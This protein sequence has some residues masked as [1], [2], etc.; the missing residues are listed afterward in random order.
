MRVLAATTCK[1]EDRKT[2][3]VIRSLASLGASVTVGGDRFLGE[4]FYSRLLDGRIRYPHPNEHIEGFIESL[5]RFTTAGN[6]DVLLPMCDYTTLAVTANRDRLSEHTG[7]ILSDYHAL[8]KTRHKPDTIKIAQELGIETPET[9]LVTTETDLKDIAGRIRY[10]CVIKPRMGAGGI[11]LMFPHSA[12]ELIRFYNREPL[13]SDMVF[14]HENPMIQEYVPGETHDVC[15][16]FNKGEARAVLTQKRLMMYPSRGGVGIINETTHEPE[17]MMKAIALLEAL[18]WHG[19]AQVEF[20]MDSRDGLPKLIE[21]NGRFWGTLDLA[22]KA[23]M[24]FPLLACRIAMEG[25][26]DPVFDYK[27][28]LKY[29]WVY[30]YAIL[31]VLEERGGWRTLREFIRR[32]PGSASDLWLR[33]PV[34][35]LAETLYL[36]LRALG[37]ASKKTGRHRNKRFKGE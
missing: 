29:R 31:C 20:K 18:K 11:G 2:L 17:L 35:V 30:P 16:L 22:V 32:E 12:Q 9:F 4:A 13:K 8:L 25:D 3:C 1:P 21:I 10:P 37:V 26:I 36:A 33:D 28:G 24:N 34:P 5:V 23:G 7:L 15:L 14:V 27:V 19:P 6:F